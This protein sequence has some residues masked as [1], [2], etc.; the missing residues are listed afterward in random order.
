M[1]EA[2]EAPLPRET[3]ATC[4]D[5]AMLPAEGHTG[6]PTAFFDPVSRC[7]SYLPDLPNF[8]VG[9]ILAGEDGHGRRSVEAR[10]DARV[11]VRPLGL[12]IPPAYS[13]QYELM[14]VRGFGRTRSMRCPHQLDGGLCGIW[15]HRNG[16]CA[17]WYCKHV[18]GAAGADLWREGIERLLR[19]AEDAVSLHCLVELGVEPDGL[20]EMLPQKRKP[21]QGEPL[22]TVDDARY[23]AMWGRFRGKER[24]L[25][26][27]CAEI[28]GALSFRD[29]LGVAGPELR[30]RLTNAKTLLAKARSRALP[31]RVRVGRFTV[32]G[33]SDGGVRVEGYSDFDPLE[34]PGSVLGVLHRFDGR[35]TRDVRAEIQR[36]EGIELDDDFLRLLVDFRILVDAAVSRSG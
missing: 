35:P 25:F 16:V 1:A 17:T 12:A 32:L 15:L 5:C 34:L 19:S 22:D 29:V 4:D 21:P 8:L 31:A 26:L 23:A 27:R 7:C 20:S 10:I 11:G 3:E 9:G 2:L 6:D 24:A 14:G 28:A 18:R 36:E 13:A 30:L 33:T